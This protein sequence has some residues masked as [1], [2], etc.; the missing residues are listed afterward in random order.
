MNLL[1]LSS[2]YNSTC[3][4]KNFDLKVAAKAIQDIYI[5]EEETKSYPKELCKKKLEEHVISWLLPTK[6]FYVGV[7]I[8]GC[9]S[10]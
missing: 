4:Y 6:E 9:A 10:N 7:N 3:D 2:F 8:D 1:S 5:V